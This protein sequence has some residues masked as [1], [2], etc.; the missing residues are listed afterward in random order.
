VEFD[1][2]GK[3]KQP[4]RRVDDW[5]RRM[6]DSILDVKTEIRLALDEVFDV[7]AV[8][9]HRRRVRDRSRFWSRPTLPQRE[10]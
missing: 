1:S 5:R 6:G 7:K 10:P 3:I 4:D 8:T 9:K 2:L